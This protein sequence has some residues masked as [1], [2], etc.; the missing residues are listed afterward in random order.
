MKTY[1]YVD[2]Y[3]ILNFTMNLYLIMVTAMLR[4][5]KCH[6]LRFVV[7]S[8]IGALFSVFVTYYLWEQLSFQMAAALL[9]MGVLVYLAYGREGIRIWA[10]DLMVF[11][12]LAFFTGG[13]VGA[14][15]GFLM[16]I[17]QEEKADSIGLIFLSIFLL[18]LL[19]L[20]FRFTLIRQGQRQKSIRWAKVVHEGREMEI[21]VLYDTGNQLV[22]PYTGEGVAI[23][24]EELAKTLGLGNSQR[25]VLIPFHS[26]GGSGL[27]KAYRMQEMWMEDGTC[28][29]NFL[30]AVSE[31]LGE[32][33][34]IQMILNIT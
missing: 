2:F 22:S 6:F 20:L 13:L 25:P 17:L 3:F 10:G 28:R 19:F 1:L 26:I 5:K 24:S 14:V 7:L 4:Q 9:Q 18:F 27:L 16:R 23:I 32:G 30:A 8:G 34:G 15:Q 21:Q 12:F 11:L 31:N 33:Q 29:K